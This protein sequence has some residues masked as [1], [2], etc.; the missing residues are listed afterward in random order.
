M[1]RISFTTLVISAIMLLTGCVQ[2][3][4]PEPMPLNRKD[5]LYFPTKFHGD[6]SYKGE[7]EMLGENITIST[8]YIDLGDERIVLNEENIL[9]KFNGYLILNTKTDHNDRFSVYLAKTKN[10][11]LSLY[12]FDGE[13]EEKVAIWKEVLGDDGVEEVK[14]NDGGIEVEEIKLAVENN[15]TFRLLINK[16]GITHMGDYVK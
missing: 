6:W 9:R 2:V 5:K 13:D 15:T 1:N 12:N 7:N 8:K 10:G 16:G 11:V 4:F 3:T 14:S